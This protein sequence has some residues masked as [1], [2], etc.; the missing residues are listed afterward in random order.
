MSFLSLLYLLNYYSHVSMPHSY[1]ATQISIFHFP[2][3]EQIKK[4][5]GVLISP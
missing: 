4:Y 1:L 5:P 2:V 3:S